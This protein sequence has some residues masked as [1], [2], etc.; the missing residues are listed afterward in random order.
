M[1]CFVPF[2]LFSQASLPDNFKLV[3]QQDFEAVQAI[4]QLEMTDRSAWK[5]GVG[6]N[7]NTLALVGKSGYTA[8]VRS[9]SN[10]A[11]IKGV[12]VKDFVLEIDLNQT[13]KEYGHRDLCIFFGFQ[14]ATNFY[15]VHLASQADDHANN[16]FLVND[17]PRV[18]I[19][20]KTTSGTN[21]GETADWHKVRIERTGS[22]GIIRVYFDDM[23]T[24]VME[25][26]DTHFMDGLIGIGSFDDVGQFD[27]IRI[28]AE[29][30]L[31]EKRGL[32]E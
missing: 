26:K 6:P 16:I 27:N 28:W 29:E 19:A 1:A 32:F 3:Y 20:S 15:Y 18:K 13:G 5:L 4:D 23:H 2:S 22:A 21:W 10:I 31:E 11:M 25:A 30:S 12:R 9:P 17:E 8:A 7:G 14:N 24:P